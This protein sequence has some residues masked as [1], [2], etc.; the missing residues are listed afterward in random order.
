M[1]KLSLRT[2]LTLAYTG[3]LALLGTALTIGYHRVLVAE[4]DGDATAALQ[5]I[6][7]GLHGYLVFRDGEPVLDYSKDDPEA[8][9]FVEEASRYYQ[10]FDANDGRLLVQSA[11]LASLGLQYTPKEIAAF[12]QG[13]TIQDIQT[14]RGRLRIETSLIT[15]TPRETYLLQV[16]EPLDRF[17][18]SMASIERLL[19][20][21]V[22]IGLAIAAFVGQWMAGRALAPLRRL[23]LATRE[24]GVGDL[25][26]RLPIRGAND[27]LDEVAGALNQALDRVE[28]TV[29]EMR[30]F[31]AALAHELRT[32]LAILRGETELA[33]TQS[34]SQDDLRQRLEIQ[35][36]EFDKLTRLINQLLTLARAEGGEL[37][38][39]EDLIDLGRLTTVVAEQIEAVAEAKGVR[40]AC[41]TDANVMVRGDEGWL[42]RLLLILLDNA[43]KFTRSGGRIVAKVSHDDRFARLDVSDT[44]VG[45]AAESLPHVFDR[46]YRADAARSGESEGAGLGLALA[47]WVADHHHGEIHVASTPGTGS[48]FTVLLPRVMPIAA[49]GVVKQS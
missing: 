12:R 6:T 44:G 17:D 7:R 38:L 22:V 48:T 27:E 39:A 35:L 24:I 37:I 47:K 23:A 41:E 30:Q 20:W 45:I 13:P 19:A 1:R 11:S 2:S 34:I 5:E 18:R 36:E 29:G 9:A 43:V 14:D 10:V 8:V 16:G 28:H 15:P 40:L 33:L 3:L 4:L 49:A 32:P 26:R 42:E 21:R 46:F 25:A 31:S